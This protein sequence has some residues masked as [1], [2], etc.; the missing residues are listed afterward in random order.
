MFVLAKY[1]KIVIGIDQSYTRTGLSLGA[2]GRLLKVSSTNF[3]GCKIK[4]QKRLHLADLLTRIIEANQH[5]ASEVVIL[6]ERIR[7]FSHSNKDQN[8]DG[9][10]GMFISTNYIKATGALIATIVDTAYK[11]GIPVYSVDTRAWKSK[12]VGTSKKIKGN[13]KLATVRHITNLGFNVSRVNKAG[14]TVYDDDAADSGCICLY[15]FIPE[16]LQS[17]KKEE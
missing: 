7:T 2:D 12:I 10:N 5:K 8:E 6:C 15:G 13:P 1:K 3:R 17:L 9:N 16:R 14:K 4:S 11:Y